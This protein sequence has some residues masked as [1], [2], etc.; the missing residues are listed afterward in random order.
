MAKRDEYVERVKKR[1]DQ[2]NADIRKL[3][4]A[5]AKAEAGARIRLRE[6]IESLRRHREQAQDQIRRIEDAAEEAWHEIARGAEEAWRIIG[7]VFSGRQSAQSGSPAEE[8]PG[9]DDSVVETT[10][11]EAPAEKKAPAKK[12]SKKPTAKS[13]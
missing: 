6:Q 5:Y 12:S 7:D 9:E 8:T 1:L 4:D 2:W 11:A 10:T 3:E 13:A